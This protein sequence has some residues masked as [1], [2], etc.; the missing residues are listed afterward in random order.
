MFFLLLQSIY[1]RFAKL[2]F[3]HLYVCNLFCYLPSRCWRQFLMQNMPCF[4]TEISKAEIQK[5]KI[6]V[7]ILVRKVLQVTKYA[8][9]Y[10][11][12]TLNIIGYPRPNNSVILRWSDVAKRN[13]QT[14]RK[15]L[16]LY[17]ELLRIWISPLSDSGISGWNLCKISR[18]QHRT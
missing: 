18:K 4:V 5:Q 10:G 16:N 17:F 7:Y 3:L 6:L 14:W 13:S 11:C 2:G 8:N 9:R 1:A 15:Q 12:T